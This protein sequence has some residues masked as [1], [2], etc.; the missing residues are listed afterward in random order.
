MTATLQVG[1]Y[2]RV[3]KVPGPWE[4]SGESESDRQALVGHVGVVVECAVGG[5]GDDVTT[6]WAFVRFP[7]RGRTNIFSN[8]AVARN[9]ELGALTFISRPSRRLPATMLD[10]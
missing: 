5:V 1:D 3:D 6:E 9:I 7:Y 2:V 4:G 8:L 10:N